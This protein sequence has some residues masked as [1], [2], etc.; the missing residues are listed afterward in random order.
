MT[1]A[2]SIERRC[3]R[4][5]RWLVNPMEQHSDVGAHRRGERK[6]VLR[7]GWLMS[8]YSDASME[9]ITGIAPVVA[10]FTSR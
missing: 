8:P 7:R 2:V 1:V 10:T 3:H 5:R 6:R 9:L 4:R